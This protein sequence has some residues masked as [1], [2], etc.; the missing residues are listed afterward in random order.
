MNS[1][2]LAIQAA[3]ANNHFVTVDST[4]NYLALECR[5]VSGYKLVEFD[6]HAQGNVVRITGCASTIFPHDT[7]TPVCDATVDSA[8]G[9]EAALENYLGTLDEFYSVH[10]F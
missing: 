7:A 1:I 8:A 6:C 3:A 2:L 4:E 9:F 5:N 10:R